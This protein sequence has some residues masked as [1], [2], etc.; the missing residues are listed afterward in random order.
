MG[1]FSSIGSAFKSIGQKIGQGARWVGQ[2]ALQ[3][4]DYGIQGLKIA[5]DFA[6]KYTLGLDHFIPY[7][8][9]IKA[10]IDI[11][12]HLR[13]MAKGEEKLNLSNIADMGLDTLAGAM[14]AYGGKAELQ[15]IKGGMKMFK[16]ARATGS[17]LAEASKIAGGRIIRGYGLHKEQLKQMGQEGLKGV[18]NVAKAVRKGDPVAIAK[19]GAGI[20]AGVGAIEFKKGVDREKSQR[21]SINPIPTPRILQPPQKPIPQ[22]PSIVPNSKPIPPPPP[23]PTSLV[24]RK[25]F[26]ISETERGSVVN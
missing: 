16:T 8:S 17:S 4:V 13:K 9:A 22:A 25:P 14:S 11:S 10:G 6:D 5:S 1:F 18:V 15:G 7:Y 20:G 12:D 26:N 3:G 2:K 24:P 23:P 19:V 21:R